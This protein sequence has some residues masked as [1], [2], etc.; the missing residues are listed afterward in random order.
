MPSE[1]GSADTQS[2]AEPAVPGLEFDERPGSSFSEHRALW[3]L[4][5][6][7]LLWW[8][9]QLIGASS[10][11][12]TVPFVVGCNLWGLFTMLAAWLPE[13]AW[14]FN[15]RLVDAIQWTTA[16]VVVAVFIVWGVTTVGGLSP[17]GTDAMAF[18]QYAAHLAMH[19]ANPY[20]HSMQPA[21]SLFR[22]PTSY[23]TYAFNGTPVTTLSYPAQSFLIYIPFLAINWTQNMAPLINVSAW[24]LTILLMFALAPRRLRPIALILGGFSIWAQFAVGGVTDVIF[25]PLMLV[26]AYKWDRFGASRLSYIGPVMF[27]LAMGIK[28]NPWPTLPF[29]LIA[30]CLDESGR[31][32]LR[33]GIERAG[34]YL[35][36]ALAAL[37]IPNIPYFVTA[38]S[39]WIKGVFTPVFANMVPT[40]QGSISLSLYLHMGGGSITAY[41]LAAAAVLALLLVAFIGTYPLL[42][43]G[44][45]VLPA[46]A[47]FFADRSNMNYFISLIPVGFIAASTVDHPQVRLRKGAEVIGTGFRGGLDRVLSLGGWFRSRRWG[48]ASLVLALASAA[49][50]LY[51]LAA[52]QPLRIRITSIQTTGPTTHIE[53]MSVSVTNA[54]GRTETPAFDVLRSGYNSTFWHIIDGPKSLAPGRSASYTLQ[55]EN[56]DSEPSVYG[57]FS[58]V[59]Y[60]HAPDAFSVSPTYK[61]NLYHLLF[62]PSAVDQTIRAG[63]RLRVSVQIYNRAG[64]QL[65]RAGVAVRLQQLFWTNTGPKRT[66]AWIDCQRLGRRATSY[67]NG[68]GIASFTVEGTRPTEYPVTYSASLF[69]SQFGYVYSDSGSLD[70][71][72]GPSASGKIIRACTP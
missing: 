48:A 56:A 18:N 25:M 22:T 65:H 5:G 23:Y 8:S 11:S 28:Q 34:R 24:A 66:T 45:F 32:D 16:L 58:V 20:A 63:R 52:P 47:F 12:W 44:F 36:V 10:L 72:F 14:G 62:S 38:P 9:W 51:S 31:T 59:G 29:I 1:L 4:V 6:I 39:A 61:P 42:R 3:M 13:G 53:Q 21:F 41:T 19:G 46:L 64:G 26:A 70:V 15:T 55:S 7:S 17:Y 57:G 33:H 2:G 49:V 40:G 54:S 60:D 67:T 27:G 35:G 68:Q 43:G 37:V 71:T 69:N 50:I 30:L